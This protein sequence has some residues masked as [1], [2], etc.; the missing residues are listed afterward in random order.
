MIFGQKMF[1]SKIFGI[2]SK[3]WSK[4]VWKNFSS[5]KLG[6]ENNFAKIF[7]VKKYCG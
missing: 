2:K 6:S 7:W 4:K 1:C 3:V 5:K